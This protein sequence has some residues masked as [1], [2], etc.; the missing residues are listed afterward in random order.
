M[1]HAKNRR[2]ICRALG[3]VLAGLAGIAPL[4]AFAGTATATVD[5]SLTIQSSCSVQANPLTFTGQASQTIDANSSVTVSC[6]AVPTGN[7]VSLSL[8]QGTNAQGTTRYLAAADGTLVPY[9]IYSDAAHTQVWGSG[10]QSVSVPVDSGSQVSVPMYGQVP[11]SG[12]S[13]A[14]GTYSDTVVVTLS[15]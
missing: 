7:A 11:A 13:V 14:T 3:L 9:A 6:S 4:P 12:S 5:V 8:D 2:K 1:A 15:F 10:G